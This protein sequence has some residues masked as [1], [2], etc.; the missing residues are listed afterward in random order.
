LFALIAC[1]FAA[2]QFYGGYGHG[3]GYSHGLPADLLPATVQ[4]GLVHH[5]NGAVTPALTPSVAAATHAHLATK[6]GV[7]GGHGGYG[8]YGYLG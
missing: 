1:A 6:F 2:P 3:Y 4:A 8:R 7:Y 5:P